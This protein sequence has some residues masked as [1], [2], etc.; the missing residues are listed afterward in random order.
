MIVDVKGLT[1]AQIISALHN[2]TKPLGIGVF[3][4]Q[5][6]STPE[7]VEPDLVNMREPDG[8]LYVDYFRGRPL[9][10]RLTASPDTVDV[11]LFDRDAGPGA[12]AQAL[13]GARSTTASRVA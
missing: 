7:D 12:G 11:R 6:D 4:A 8:S 3:H 1:Q 5:G 9:K 10:I 13:E 2:A